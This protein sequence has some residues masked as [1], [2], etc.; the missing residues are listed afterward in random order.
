MSIEGHFAALLT[1]L[2]VL[3]GMVKELDPHINIVAKAAS[4]LLHLKSI[5]KTMS[6]IIE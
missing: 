5:D 6:E 2:I 1:N 3:E 4:F